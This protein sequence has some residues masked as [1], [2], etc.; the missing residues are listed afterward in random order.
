MTKIKELPLNDRP[1]ERLINIG[2]S[3]LSNDELLAII[4]KTGTKELS[5]KELALEILKTK[6]L[7]DL[8][9]I[10]Y[11]ELIKI[12]G[13]GSKKAS[14]LLACI[15]FSKRLNKVYDSIKGLKMNHPSIIYNYYKDILKYEKR[16]HFYA[17]YLDNSGVIIKDK[18]LFLGTITYSMVSHSEIFKEETADGSDVLYVCISSGVSGTIQSATMAAKEFD[19]KVKVFDSKHFC[20]SEGLLAEYAKRL[21]DEGLSLDEIYTKLDLPFFSQSLNAFSVPTSTPSFALTVI[22][23]V[24]QA[25]MPS[26]TPSSKSKRPGTS[27][28]LTFVSLYS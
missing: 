12:K 15:E 11:E 22:S 26:Y 6:K 28:R 20:I 9:N 24:S 4:L 23:T 19:N 14:V 7:S 10:T 8:A 2:A 3:A 5:S 25:F 17:V 13:I 21:S 1:I 16:E 18:L 27:M